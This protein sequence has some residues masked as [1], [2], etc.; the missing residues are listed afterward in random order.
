M[1]IHWAASIA[2]I[3]N[4]TKFVDYLEPMVYRAARIHLKNGKGP[5][6]GDREFLVEVRKMLQPLN[7]L[8]YD[9][10]DIGSYQGSQTRPGDGL[11][12]LVQICPWSFSML[13][14]SIQ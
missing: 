14:P 6:C 9:V 7:T 10:G 12:L 5:H 8:A 3:S 13:L 1:F 11:G 2:P 4:G